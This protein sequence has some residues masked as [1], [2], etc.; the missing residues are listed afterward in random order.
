MFGKNHSEVGGVMLRFGR[1][2]LV[3]LAIAP[4]NVYELKGG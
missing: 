2:V 3:A 1:L 4:A